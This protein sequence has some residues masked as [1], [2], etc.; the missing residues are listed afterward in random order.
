MVLENLKTSSIVLPLSQGFQKLI[1]Y[2]VTILR[3]L[4][5]QKYCLNSQFLDINVLPLHPDDLK[6]LENSPIV[7]FNTMLQLF[8]KIITYGVTI[9][10][11]SSTFPVFGHF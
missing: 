2:I 11:L 3:P 4:S 9:L 7:N 8:K 1:A 5:K 6:N 10:K